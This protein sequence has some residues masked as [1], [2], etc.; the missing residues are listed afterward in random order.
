MLM[1]NEVFDFRPGM[2]VKELGLKK[3]QGWSYRQTANGGHFGR[4]I[5]PWEK[6]NKVEAV[7]SALKV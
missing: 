6:T 7:R 3:P 2:I 4:D 5:F 1:A